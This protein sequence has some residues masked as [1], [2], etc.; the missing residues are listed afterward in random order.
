MKYKDPTE[1]VDAR[2]EDLLARMT[3]PEKVGQ[4]I[5]MDGHRN[6]LDELIFRTHIGSLL[7]IQNEDLSKA[8]DKAAES[9]LGIPILFGDD[10]IHGHSFHHGATIFPTQLGM[11]CSWNVDLI[12]E[13]ARVTAKEVRLTGLKWTFS[14]V[15][16]IARD[17]RWGRVG[18]TFGEDPFLIGEFAAAMIRGYQGSGL[19]DNEAILA[20]AK[21]YAAYSETQGGRDASEADVSRRKMRSFFLPPFERA[22]REGCLSFMTGYQSINGVPSTA[23]RWLLNDLLR[24]EWGF[25]GV[26]VT[27]WDNVGRMHWEQKIC[28]TLKDAVALAIKSG[29]DLAMSTPGFFEAALEAVAEGL[30][31]EAEI[32]VI[33]RRL[34][35]L[36]FK[37]GL[38]ENPGKPDLEAQKVVIG[39]DEHRQVN[40]EI[41]RESLVLLRNQ[42]LLPLADHTPTKIAVIGPNADDDQAQMGDWAGASGQVSWIADGHPRECSKTVLDGIRDLAP[43]GSEIRYAKGADIAILVEEDNPDGYEDGQVK[44]VQLEVAQDDPELIAEA[45]AAAEASDVVVLVVGDAKPFYGECCSTATLDLQGGQ[46]ALIQAVAQ[47]G[48]PLIVVLI[49]SKPLILPEAIQNAE[50]LIEAFNPGMTGGTA[51]AEAIFGKINPCGRLPISF[52]YHVGQ[53]PIYYNQ[54]R[55]QHGNKYA[56][57]TQ[58]P[59]YAFGEGLSYTRFEYGELSMPKST[60]NMNDKVVAEIEV[61]NVGDRDGVE[62]V[63]AYISDLVTS[64]TWVDKELKAFVRVPLK[65]GEKKTVQIE[66]PVADCSIV[67]AE[68]LRVVEPGDFDLLVG[69]SSRKSALKQASFQITA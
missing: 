52:P 2:T 31:D 32:D 16:C 65:A 19:D 44:K 4:L 1:S 55:G 67:N 49:N 21:H 28:P 66:F 62:I 24:D 23:N 48:K 54:V 56:D 45:V 18:E 17:L 42:G 57:L 3:L 64:A 29:N 68:G 61:A 38:F 46:Q 22:V 63:Q 59:L 7:H 33:V 13:S 41:T 51:I 53:Q 40:L 10:C 34:L 36:K 14:P 25:D 6:D 26:L 5:Q 15:L 8:I 35:R 47:T 39:C 27:D 11:A 58:E 60:L 37:M 9:R 50:A 69:P 12:Q 20:T 30:V 43:A